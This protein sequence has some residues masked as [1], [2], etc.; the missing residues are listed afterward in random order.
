MDTTSGAEKKANSRWVDIEF[1]KQIEE[2]ISKY[3]QENFSFCV[4]KVDCKKERLFW[5]SKIAS[6]LAQADYIVPSSAWLGKDSPKE[7]IKAFGLWQVNGL[8]G[9][10][11]NEEELYKLTALLDEKSDK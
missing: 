2:R 11:I 9:E 7:K 6:T 10:V 3:I 5:E 1:E 8:E 4:F